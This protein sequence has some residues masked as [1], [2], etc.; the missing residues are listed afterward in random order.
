MDQMLVDV[1]E[2]SEIY[3]GD[4]VVLIG[5]SHG[6]RIPAELYAE[7]TDSITNEV[8]SRLGARLERIAVF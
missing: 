3:S 6:E 1:T 7:W 4:E 2:I 8:V 5:Q